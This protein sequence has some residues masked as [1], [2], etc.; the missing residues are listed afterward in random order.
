MTHLHLLLVALCAVLIILSAIPTERLASSYSGATPVL[1]LT[2]LV[3]GVV[4]LLILFAPT[5]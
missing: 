3:A 2:A 5:S 1:T 4:C